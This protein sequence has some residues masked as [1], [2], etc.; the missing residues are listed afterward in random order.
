MSTVCLPH[1]PQ[2]H[3][4]GVQLMSCSTLGR[5]PGNFLPARMLARRYKRKLLLFPLTL[6][7][8]FSA[9]DTTAR[10]C[11]GRESKGKK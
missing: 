11:A 2:T 8:D 4:C 10:K 5:S 7:L 3:C 1:L 9:A 6:G